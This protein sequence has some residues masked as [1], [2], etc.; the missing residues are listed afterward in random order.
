LK[1]EV[2]RES[3]FE[4]GVPRIV[5]AGDREVGVVRWDGRYYGVRNH[6]PDQGGP[7]CAGAVRTTL[8]S[9]AAGDFVELSLEDGRPIIACPWHHYEFDLETGSELRGGRRVVTYQVSVDLDRVFV[10]VPG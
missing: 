2:G 4:E 3:D 7:L 6:C 10:E 8:S 9:H 1:I 5:A